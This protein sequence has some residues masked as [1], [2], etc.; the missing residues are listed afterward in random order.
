MEYA[1]KIRLV[2]LVLACTLVFYYVLPGTG[3]VL[4]AARDEV[5]EVRALPDLCR[6]TTAFRACTSAYG[7]LTLLRDNCGS[8][9]IEEKTDK[10]VVEPIGE[11]T[12]ENHKEEI[13][14]TVENEGEKNEIKVEKKS[15][16][17][18]EVIIVL[19]LVSV[20][21][22]LADCFQERKRRRQMRSSNS[23]GPDMMTMRGSRLEMCSRR[24]SLADLTMSRHARRESQASYRPPGKL[25][26]PKQVN[27][28]P[29]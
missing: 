24:M 5:D 3:D 4:D 10:V 16:L 18:Y 2:L 22:S 25:S 14:Q 8:G 29:P 13:I 15:N 28:G 21:L 17:I 9:R 11:V 6:M 27:F 12:E 26:R 7:L 20:T 1:S 23:N 19:L